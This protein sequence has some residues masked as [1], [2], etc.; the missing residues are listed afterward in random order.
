MKQGMSLPELIISITILFIVLASAFSM[1]FAIQ[2]DLIVQ[3]LDREMYDQ[4]STA[5][6]QILDSVLKSIFIYPPDVNIVLRDNSRFNLNINEKV[7]YNKLLTI[8]P[9]SGGY[10]L[11]AY[12]SVPR[13]PQDALLPNSRMLL[14]YKK[15]INWAP[16]YNTFTLTVVETGGTRVIKLAKIINYPTNITFTTG[17][18]PKVI[19][20][21]IINNGFTVNYY[22]VDVTSA[23]TYTTYTNSITSRSINIQQV[24]VTIRAQRRYQ[25]IYRNKEIKFK[26]AVFLEELPIAY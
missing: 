16:Q 2:R 1:W 17:E 7:S 12:L 19:A 5:K 20:D 26:G 24:E 3:R 8:S 15:F 23:Y 14:Y 6:S 9:T 4:L 13:N 21:Y 10:Y 11:N 22:V 25:N 18:G